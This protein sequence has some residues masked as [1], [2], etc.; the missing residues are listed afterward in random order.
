MQPLAVFIGGPFHHAILSSGIFDPE[1]KALI[2]SLITSV[3]KAGFTVLSAHREEDFGNIALEGPP[4]RI[5]S[6]DFSWMQKCAVYACLLPNCEDDT[7]YRSDGCCIELG[8]ASALKKPIILIREINVS[9]SELIIGL[10]ALGTVVHLPVQDITHNPN[11]LVETLNYLLNN[12][13]DDK[14]EY[15]VT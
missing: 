12:S 9:F 8:W 2:I 5:V 1:L 10:G 11:I 15:P 6:R 13:Q 14:Q 4:E 7:A 3:E